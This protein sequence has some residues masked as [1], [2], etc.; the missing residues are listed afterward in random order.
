MRTSREFSGDIWVKRIRAGLWE[1]E[2]RIR[3]SLRV[4]FRG[5]REVRVT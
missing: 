3:K 2:V 1:R 5:K 4:L